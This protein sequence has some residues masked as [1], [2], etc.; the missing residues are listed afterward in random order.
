MFTIGELASAAG[1]T[2]RTVRH[3]H[4]VGLLQEPA[5]RSNGYREYDVQAVLR[6]VRIRRLTQ[7]GLSLPEVRDALG[8]DDER[9]LREILTELVADLGRQEAAVREQRQRLLA[10]LGRERDLMLPS[11]LAEILEQVRRLVPDGQLVRREGEL[12]E[13]LEATMPPEQFAQLTEQYRSAL[14]DPQ[15][16]AGS[17]T[18]ARRFEALASAAPDDVEVAAVAAEFIALGRELFPQPAAGASAAGSEQDRVW[19]AYRATLSPAQQRCLLLV[20]QEYGS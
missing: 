10:L 6:L 4:S 17:I 20:E 8:G 11:A 14:A 1:T 19:V 18:A 15:Q 3:Y 16:V 5:R 9:D 12:L 2:T 7:W 13:L